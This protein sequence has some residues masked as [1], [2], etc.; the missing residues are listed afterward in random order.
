[1]LNDDH[2]ST[3]EDLNSTNGVYIGSQRVRRHRLKDQDLIKLGDYEL[4]Y[5][6][7]RS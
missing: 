6:D 3:I 4:L 1:M 5:L 7:Q 2:A